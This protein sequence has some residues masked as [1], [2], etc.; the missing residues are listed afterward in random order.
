M[1][2]SQSKTEMIQTNFDVNSGYNESATSD[3]RNL[4]G[5]KLSFN[6]ARVKPKIKK[7]YT[8]CLT[9]LSVNEILRD[10]IGHKNFDL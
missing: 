3:S 6:L 9:C 10:K 5:V 4:V 2:Y 1:Y 8:F 7:C